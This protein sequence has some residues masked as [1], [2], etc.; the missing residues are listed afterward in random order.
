[1]PGENAEVVRRMYEAYLRGDVDEAMVHIHPDVRVDFSV[2]GD[3]GVRYGQDALAEIVA[4]WISTWDDYREELDE[5]RDLGE[6][7]LLVATQAG[8]GKGS[9]VETTR[10]WAW[11]Y[12]VEEGLVTSVTAYDDRATAIAAASSAE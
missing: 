11:L 6:E 8:R 10:Q 4:G 7:V 12:V 5:L 3:T 9:G 1:M 2:R